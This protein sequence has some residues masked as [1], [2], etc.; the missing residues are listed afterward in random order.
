MR[1]HWAYKKQRAKS[2]SNTNIDRWYQMALDNGATGGKLVGAG[3][4]GFLMFLAQDKMRL[5]HTM[6]R[7][8]LKEVRFRFS[9]E[10]TKIFSN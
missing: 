8:G 2:M 9:F 4:G 3:G 6:I 5:R 1:E 10:G 7:A